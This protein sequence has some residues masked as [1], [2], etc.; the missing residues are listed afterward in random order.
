MPK[1][2]RNSSN[3]S[4]SSPSSD[5]DYDGLPDD[6]ETGG[7]SNAAGSFTTF[8][9]DP[10]SDDDGTCDGVISVLPECVADQDSDGDGIS[11]GVEVANGT[12]P[13]D[14]AYAPIWQ[15]M[16]TVDTYIPA[17]E[18]EYDKPFMMAVEDVFSIKGRGTVVT[19]RV[20]RG[21]IHTGDEVEIVVLR[22]LG[23][24]KR[25]RLRLIDI[26]ER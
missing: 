18:R 21:R 10:D 4:S 22:D 3:G 24:R 19:G 9:N 17:P 2:T 1:G 26:S 14:P 12:D 20:E 13:N 23:D 7:W 8:P 5:H 25:V 15:L 6:V 11:D 16:D